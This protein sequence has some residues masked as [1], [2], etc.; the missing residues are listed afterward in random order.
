MR[1]TLSDF[2]SCQSFSSSSD[3]SGNSVGEENAN[4]GDDDGFQP[5]NGKMCVAFANMFIRNGG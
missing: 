4:D 1:D 3:D 2:G 5:M